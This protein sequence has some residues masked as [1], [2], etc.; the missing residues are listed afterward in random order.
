MYLFREGQMVVTING[1]IA[2][3]TSPTQILVGVLK[4]DETF[5]VETQAESLEALNIYKEQG[6]DIKVVSPKIRFRSG[7]ETTVSGKTLTVINILTLK[8]KITKELIDFLS[9]NKIQF[10]IN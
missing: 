6:Y 2:Q 8:G 7:K 9:Q 3:V 1:Q 5:E 10:T 4:A